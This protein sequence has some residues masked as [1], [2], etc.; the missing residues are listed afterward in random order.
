MQIL[1][2]RSCAVTQARS[3]NRHTP[4]PPHHR[5][6]TGAAAALPSAVAVPPSL[7]SACEIRGQNR[8]KRFSLQNQARRNLVGKVNPAGKPYRVMHCCRTV[9]SLTHGVDLVRNKAGTVTFSGLQTCGSVWI[10]PICADAVAKKRELEVQK[11][12]NAHVVAGGFSMMMS[13]THG[14]RRR[15]AL[16]PMVKG[17]SGAMRAMTSWRAYKDLL[18]GVGY[19]GDKIRALETT[20]GDASGWHPH[21][22]ELIFTDRHLDAAEIEALRLALF[23]LWAKACRKFDLPAPNEKHGVDVAVA[24]TAAAYLAKANRAEKWSAAKEMTRGHSKEAKQVERF[25]P[26]DLLRAGASGHRPDLMA[27]LFGEYADAYHGRRQLVWTAGMK[28]RF[29]IEEVSDEAA[30]GDGESE[31]NVTIVGNIPA[32][33]WKGRVV[34]PGVDMRNDVLKTCEIGGMEAVYCL[35]MSD[36]EGMAGPPH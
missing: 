29:G 2:D 4:P 17:Y 8:Q 16:R 23:A 30:A 32:A 15:D 28:E 11:A 7:G 33:I 10:C 34:R 19:T 6:D 27:E 25:T 31:T 14:H 22:H 20:W 18:A 36:H 26:F 13:Y 24:L 12:L 1:P 3:Q 9:E 5:A 21:G 35:V